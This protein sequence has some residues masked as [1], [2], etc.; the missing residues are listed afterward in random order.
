MFKLFTSNYT[1]KFILLFSFCLPVGHGR[2][3]CEPEAR[4]TGYARIQYGRACFWQ[5]SRSGWVLFLR[6]PFVSVII[7]P[8]FLTCSLSL[9]P[10][11]VTQILWW[12]RVARNVLY[13]VCY[14]HVNR[15]WPPNFCLFALH[16]ISLCISVLR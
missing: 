7:L 3:L 16:C 9:L 5:L 2:L 8:S 1:L 10:H 6:A 13:P 12:M 11:L 4:Q 15:A 14:A